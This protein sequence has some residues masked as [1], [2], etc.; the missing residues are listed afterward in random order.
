VGQ[1]DHERA[2]AELARCHLMALPSEDEAFG[3]A[4]AEALACGVPAI[5]CADEGGPEEI[6]A[7]GEG[8]VL[9]PHRDPAE[10][11]GT[12]RDLLAD[13]ES[14]HAL[15]TA[16]RRTADARLSWERCGA[17]TLSIYHA[18]LAR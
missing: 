15:S 12:V 11:A 1:L 17:A 10:L 5:G 14:L 3:V 4:Y 18:A 7:L 6:A 8:M 9:V 13:G 2:V 16:A